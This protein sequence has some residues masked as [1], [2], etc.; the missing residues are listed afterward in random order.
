MLTQRNVR[1]LFACLV[2]AL[3]CAAS[4]RAGAQELT[5]KGNLV[6][7]AERV[8]GF[9]L[10]KR[11]YDADNGPEVDRDQTVIGIGWGYALGSSLMNAPRVGV[12]YF[13]DEHL[14]VGGNF[15]IGSVNLEDTSSVA[16]LLAGRVGYALRLTNSIA[17]WPR[18]GLSLAVVTGDFD[19]TVFGLTLDGNF[20]F[21]PTNGGWSFLAGPVIDLGFVGSAGDNI[22][23]TEFMFGLMA[24]IEGHIEL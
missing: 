15:G 8:F 24:G 1:H 11:N 10:D 2:V 20:S 6:I 12:D 19:N 4:Q 16:I 21:S 17:F 18:G 22:S 3:L 14:T 5:R 23:Y 9:Y 13:I 7:S